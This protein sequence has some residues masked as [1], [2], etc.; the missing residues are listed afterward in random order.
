MSNSNVL[1]REYGL[2]LVD[3]YARAVTDKLL[4]IFKDL[5]A[6]KEAA[7]GRFQQWAQS[8]KLGPEDGPGF[9]NLTE[10]W[11]DNSLRLHLDFDVVPRQM[12]GLVIAGVYH[13]WERLAKEYLF[14]AQSAQH[15]DHD[16]LRRLERANFDGILTELERFKWQVRTEPFF[17]ALDRARLISNVIK[18]GRGAAATELMAVA[19]ELFGCSATMPLEQDAGADDLLLAPQ[20]FDAAVVAV[21]GFFFALPKELARDRTGW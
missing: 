18:H 14:C 15:T 2:N 6:Q 12:V 8:L 17:A 7:D 13:L 5:K 10:E 20:H 19:P 9:D 4:P 21:E 1:D 16:R 3:A 11:D